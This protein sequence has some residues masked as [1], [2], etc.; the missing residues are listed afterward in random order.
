M[1]DS[2]LTS[3]DWLAI[4]FDDPASTQRWLASLGVRDTERGARDL[5]DLA[6]RGGERALIAR[7]ASQLQSL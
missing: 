2:S 5:R 7:V 3:T 4:L 6:R 1:P